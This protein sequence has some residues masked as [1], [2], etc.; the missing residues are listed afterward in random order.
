MANRF[1]EL[2]AAEIKLLKELTV[3]HGSLTAASEKT[4][5]HVHT[6]RNARRLGYAEVETINTLRKKLLNKHKAAV[7]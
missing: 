2:T 7:H 4:G 1:L 6:I 3:E 5:L